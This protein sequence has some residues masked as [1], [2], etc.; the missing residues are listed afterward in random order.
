LGSKASRKGLSLPCTSQYSCTMPTSSEHGCARVRRQVPRVVVWV[1]SSIRPGRGKLVSR[2][3]SQVSPKKTFNVDIAE[4]LAIKLCG[5][6][7]GTLAY[8]GVLH[9][10]SETEI[11]SPPHHFVAPLWQHPPYFTTE[12]PPLSTIAPRPT[13]ISSDSSSPSHDNGIWS[14]Y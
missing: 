7:L 8:T 1:S 11:T 13:T 4:V 2:G 9:T 6:L 14:S 3:R 12:A 5:R 10:V